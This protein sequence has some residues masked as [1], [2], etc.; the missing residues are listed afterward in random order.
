MIS[1]RYAIPAILSTALLAASI[2]YAISSVLPQL[3]EASQRPPLALPNATTNHDS[4]ISRNDKHPSS[5]DH[6]TAYQRAAE[7][8]LQRAQ[9]ARASVGEPALTGHNL[10]KGRVPLPRKRPIPRPTG[11]AGETLFP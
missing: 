7:E 4:A 9:N 6:V 5:E 10:S 1:W 3:V 11:G 8:I 2:A